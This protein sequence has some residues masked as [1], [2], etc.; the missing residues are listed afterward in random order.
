MQ[1]AVRIGAVAVAV[2]LVGYAAFSLSR[3]EPTDTTK[4]AA[5]SK[6]DA[7]KERVRADPAKSREATTK[8][9]A[10][11][12]KAREAKA[13]AAVD[14]APVPTNNVEFEKGL[15]DLEA[16]VKDLESM[17]ERGIKI[18]Q[19]EWVEKYKRGNDL[20]DALM[21]SDLVKHNDGPRKEVTE[22]NVRFRDIIH[23]I[24]QP[25]S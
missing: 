1:K 24:L 25:P 11:E 19:P 14:S 17:K 20:V 6:K 3:R 23:H 4:A 12:A 13:P 5:T 22:L 21:R 18:P 8:R 7:P 9:A 15:D 16:F 10:Q 2:G